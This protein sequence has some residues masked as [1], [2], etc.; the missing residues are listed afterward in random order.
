MMTK[1]INRVVYGPLYLLFGMLFG[2]SIFVMMLLEPV[3]T[4]LDI[5]L[6]VG[7]INMHSKK[8]YK[9]K[10]IVGLSGSL[11]ALGLAIINLPEFKA[12][13]AS[14]PAEYIGY[15]SLAV[16]VAVTVLRA[17]TNNPVEW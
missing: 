17:V 15:G 13:I 2:C 4:W 6:D 10:T 9:S 14:L 12:I 1:A 7:E 11:A 16:A 5:R 8:W 3:V